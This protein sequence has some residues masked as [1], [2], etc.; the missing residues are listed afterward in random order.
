[1]WDFLIQKEGESQW[2]SL[3]EAKNLLASGRYRLVVN[4]S[5]K[6]AAIDV[7]ILY[8]DRQQNPQPLK[9]YSGK[10]NAQGLMLI[11]PYQDLTD[12]FWQITCSNGVEMG[13]IEI[14][15]K[16]QP[17]QAK[18]KPQVFSQNPA[19]VKPIPEIIK[20]EIQPKS[21]QKYEA[22]LQEII[23]SE[24]EPYLE[25]HSAQSLVRA[26]LLPD[27][28][29][30]LNQSTFFSLQGEVIPIFGLIEMRDTQFPYLIQSNFK[31]RY[32]LQ[33]PF[34]EENILSQEQAISI[35][36]LPFEFQYFLELP[37]D[38]EQTTFKGKVILETVSPSI[39]TVATQRFSLTTEKR[40]Q[41][42][43]KIVTQ[44]AEVDVDEESIS[45]YILPSKTEHPALP[46][47][48]TDPVKPGKKELTLPPL[49]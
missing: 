31:L 32:Q 18:V 6:Q 39:N 15:V 42:V 41:E 10:T 4:C 5:L 20:S 38:L 45:V 43:K 19:E 47:R 46:P 17:N 26:K 1:M 36:N 23:K 21:S 34:T 37:N 27:L 28:Q 25:Q 29:L 11:F 33:H 48:L 24:I 30:T 8:R 22:E 44:T 12:G 2:Q 7:S 16:T 3:K 35:E 14:E 49:P 13:K 40:A 9:K